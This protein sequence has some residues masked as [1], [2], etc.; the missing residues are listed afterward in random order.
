MKSVA[1]NYGIDFSIVDLRWG[2][3]LKDSENGR[4][5]EICL[6][7]I[8]DSRPYFIGILG[9]TYGSI[10]DNFTVTTR[11][12]E[13]I[14]KRYSGH[15]I[16]DIEIR[17]GVLDASQDV[18]SSFYVKEGCTCSELDAK[19]K[20][21]WTQL[22]KSIGTKL[23]KYSSLSHLEKL[24]E[25]KLIA[26]FEKI[27]PM[28]NLSDFEKEILLQKNF[29]NVASSV[30]IKS[31]DLFLS[32]KDWIFSKKAYLLI[33]GE[34][35]SGKSFFLAKCITQITTEYPSL[36]IVYYFV[37]KGLDLVNINRIK[38]VLTTLIVNIIEKQIGC[39]YIYRFNKKTER[40]ENI[41]HTLSLEDVF[42]ILQLYCIPLILIIDGIHDISNIENIRLDWIP[43]LPNHVKCCISANTN[44]AI[45]N[46]VRNRACKVISVKS[47]DKK[48]RMDFCLKILSKYSKNTTENQLRMLQTGNIYNNRFY[49][50]LMI[51]SIAKIGFVSKI[52]EE[53][54]KFTSCQSI[55][56]FYSLFIIVP[57]F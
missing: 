12:Y 22:I 23:E 44:S 6:R 15:S 35:H 32:F 38:E 50:S 56:A 24:I 26:L 8:D 21:H 42:D 1:I 10:L 57:K 55:P 20:E 39:Q 9:D 43:K 48:T 18:Y 19:K 33:E 41:T 54:K 31:S 30:Y 37:N 52:D 53:I 13:D 36:N 2:I 29:I 27:G 40:I 28:K 46:I 14:L 3:T 4:V 45:A 34:P 7:E 16:T 17:Y 49:L 47:L 25:H 5:P 11:E 51:D